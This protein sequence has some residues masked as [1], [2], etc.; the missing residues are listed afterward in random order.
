MPANSKEY[1]KN[2]MRKMIKTCDT[3]K[4]EC[5]STY[6]TY[7]AYRHKKTQKHLNFEHEKLM[8]GDLTECLIERIEKLE[9]V[10]F[11]PIE[12]I[13][14]L[15][16]NK[17]RAMC[18]LYLE[19]FKLIKDLKLIFDYEKEMN[20]ESTELD[21]GLNTE[22][23]ELLQNNKVDWGIKTPNNSPQGTACEVDVL[24]VDLPAD[25]VVLPEL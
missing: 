22:L 12:P 5:G 3:V 25:G 6:K 7:H 9:K 8:S 24:P 19:G 21:I 15:H 2:Y 4:C 1:Q 17:T 18:K 23:L 16:Q 14:K 20:G 10:V 11:P 13:M